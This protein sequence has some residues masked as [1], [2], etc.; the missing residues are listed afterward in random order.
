MLE[1]IEKFIGKE[2]VLYTINSNTQIAGV[3][4]GI[5]DNWVEIENKG[6]VE[7]V[8]A[9]YI[10][11]VREYPRNKNGKKKSAVLD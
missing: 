9:D 1:M 6:S 10:I 3:I 5:K 7:A 11:R 4:R 2:C 8:N